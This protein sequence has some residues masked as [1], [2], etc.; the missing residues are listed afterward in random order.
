MSNFLAPAVVTETLAT[1]AFRRGD[2]R[3]TGHRGHARA[4]SGTGQRQRWSSRQYLSL[5]GEPERRVGQCRRA[6]PRFEWSFEPPS[7]DWAQHRLLD[8][9]SRSGTGPRA[10]TAHGQLHE[11]IACPARS[12]EHGHRTGCRRRAQHRSESCSARRRPRRTG[13]ARQAHGAAV[14]PGRAFQVV[15]GV[16]PGPLR[17][18]GGVSGVCS[19]DRRRGRGA[20]AGTA[21]ARAPHL[22]RAV[23]ANSTGACRANG[24][25]GR[26][27]PR[28]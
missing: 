7:P 12:H 23:S 13:R 8:Q 26:A 27:Y 2:A 15:V 9:L 3:G 19:A 24:R 10:G 28:R 17:A 22:R 4:S 20:G 1:L 16:L 6:N 18:V 14:E 25:A 5:S 21:G 11:Q